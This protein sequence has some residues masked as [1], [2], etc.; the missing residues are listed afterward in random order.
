[1]ERAAKAD[2]ARTALAERGGVVIAFTGGDSS[3]VA[4]LARDALSREYPGS[5]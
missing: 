5:E 2:A 3:V 1:M 4:S